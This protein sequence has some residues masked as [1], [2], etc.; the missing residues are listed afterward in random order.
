[1]ENYIR[2]IIDICKLPFGEIVKELKVVQLGN[3][4][5]YVCNFKKILD[6][7]IDRVVLKCYKGVVEILGN[8]LTISMINKNEIV[9]KG[10]IKCFGLEVDNVNN[11]K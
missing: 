3:T 9:V 6:Y 11:K 1:M 5:I 4:A 8:D 2:E 10:L 7:T